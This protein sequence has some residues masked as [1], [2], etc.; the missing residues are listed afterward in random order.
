M[1]SKILS[2]LALVLILFSACENIMEQELI[3][4][5][6]VAPAPNV[7]ISDSIVTA[8]KGTV[9]KF[10]FTGEPDFISFSFSRFNATKSILSF[11]AQPAWGTHIA[12]TLN[13]YLFETSDTLLLNNPKIDSTTIINRKWT[14]ITSLCNLPTVANVTGKANISLNEYRGKKV[15][16]AFRYKT[17]FVADWQ[18]TWTI[19]NLQINDTLENS[20]T[21]IKTILASTMGFK[22]FDMLNMANS[23]LSADAAGVWYL[24]NP[25]SIVIKRTPSGGVLNNDWL[26]SKPIEIAKGINTLSL[27][28]TNSTT[29]FPV[30]NTTDRINSY[31]YNFTNAG[32]YT[33]TF[34]AS[35]ANYV[36]QET[37]ERKIKVIITE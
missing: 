4:D 18:P 2:V 3:F 1:K 19:G 28:T 32:E 22:P 8:P 20:T 35:N 12:N 29:V 14:D 26:I 13:V 24:A 31:S 33:L 23:Y 5:V 25:A 27:N 7:N 34:F 37:A 36:H 30:K 6:N 10:N 21:K 16:V 15:C 9:L 11:T 17:D